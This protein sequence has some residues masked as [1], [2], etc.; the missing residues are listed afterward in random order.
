M[1]KTVRAAIVIDPWGALDKTGDEEAAEHEVRLKVL[2]RP[3]RVDVIRKEWIDER[4]DVDLLLF[5]F[6]G[7]S[8]GN[9]L[10]ASNSRALIR[11]LQDHPSSLALVVSTFTY[12][13][14]IEPELFALGLIP[15]DRPSTSMMAEAETIAPPFPNLMVYNG[16]ESEIERK[17]QAWFREPS[18]TSRRSAEKSRRSSSSSR[19][20]RSSKR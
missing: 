15:E 7:M 9:D 13:H 16:H 14:G 5:D 3:A 18:A 8:I 6:G 17:I 4:L 20:K 11:W 1:R 12:A 2:L 19:P 10:M